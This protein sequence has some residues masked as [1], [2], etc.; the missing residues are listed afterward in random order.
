MVGS[1]QQSGSAISVFV[2]QIAAFIAIFYFILIRPQRQQAKK[3][4]EMLK[5]VK[6]GDEIVTAG[7]IVGE[8][9]HVKDD[10][11]TIKS[12]ESRLVIE[13]DRIAKVLTASQEPATT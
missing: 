3:H 4:A 11:I 7:G 5:Q 10:R 2:L 8:V 12:G 9:V 1:G 13:R 6:R